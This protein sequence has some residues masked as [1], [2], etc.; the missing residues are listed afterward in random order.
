MSD[1]IIIHYQ[2]WEELQEGEIVQTKYWEKGNMGVILV[3]VL[4]YG[5]GGGVLMGDINGKL[6]RQGPIYG[7]ETIS[8]IDVQGGGVGNILLSIIC[9]G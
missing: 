9:S 1:S 5:G 4:G 8:I 6:P 2:I 7:I 3:L